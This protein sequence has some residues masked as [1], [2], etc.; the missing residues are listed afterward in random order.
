M[1]EAIAIEE[2]RDQIVLLAVM[3]RECR[4][5]D[6]RQLAQCER[7]ITSESSQIARNSRE[8]ADLS[9]RGLQQLLEQLALC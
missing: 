1:S 6:P 4:S 9:L 7:D 2:R 3:T 8:D 5:N